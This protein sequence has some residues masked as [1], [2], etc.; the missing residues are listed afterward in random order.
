MADMLY[1]AT[2]Y[3]NVEDVVIAR[4]GGLK[5]RKKHDDPHPER[6]R[7]VARIGDRRDKRRLR[8]LLGGMTNFTS[9]NAL[10][11]QVLM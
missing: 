5:K 2:K 6:G 8:P 10:L 7:K 1:R 11:D 9:L 4:G 3:M